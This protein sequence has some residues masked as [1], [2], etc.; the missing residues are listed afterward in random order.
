MVP[1][2]CARRPHGAATQ[3]QADDPRARAAT[4]RCASRLAAR[5]GGRCAPRRSGREGAGTA[6]RDRAEV[7]RAARAARRNAWRERRCGSRRG[8]SRAVH[9]RHFRARE[10]RVPDP[11][12]LPGERGGR[13]G[14]SRPRSRATL[15]R[16]HAAVPRRRA[17]HPDAQRALRRPGAIAAPIR[18]GRGQRRSRWGRH[19]RGVFGPHDVVAAALVPRGASGTARFAGAVA[20]WRGRCTGTA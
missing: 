18:C 5:Q 1:R 3:P 13:C 4:R 14:P 17:L 8:V 11:G 10:R 20:G 19:R 9:L 16:L 12:K 6:Q 2:D 15:A 7:R